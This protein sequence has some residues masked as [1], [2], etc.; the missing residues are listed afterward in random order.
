MLINVLLRN[1]NMNDYTPYQ[2]TIKMDKWTKVPV[3]DEWL[4]PRRVFGIKYAIY[5]EIR[6]W[7]NNHDGGS[8]AIIEDDDMTDV[9]ISFS[10]NEDATVFL[11]R[12][13]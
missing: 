7:L 2:L 5:K 11:L 6:N 1:G 4:D 3:K 12:W 10:R 13:A 9:I 8:Y